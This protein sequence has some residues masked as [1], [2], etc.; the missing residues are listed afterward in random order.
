MVVNFRGI[1]MN[2]N[3]H[4]LE[5]TNTEPKK[6]LGTSHVCGV[7]QCLIQHHLKLAR[8]LFSQKMEYMFTL[9]HLLPEHG[10]QD[11]L[12][13]LFLGPNQNLVGGPVKNVVLDIDFTFINR[14]C[15]FGF[16]QYRDFVI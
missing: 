11:L 3:V 4:Y 8:Q 12:F 7:L 2:I 13:V 16:F 15:D 9:A 14:L 1:F 10:V 6:P 5:K